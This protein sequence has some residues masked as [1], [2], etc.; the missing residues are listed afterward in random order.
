M[1][2]LSSLP[3]RSPSKR[4]RLHPGLGSELQCQLHSPLVIQGQPT[5]PAG[6]WCQSYSS[7]R[8]R[9]L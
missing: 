8:A 7:P 4:E 1:D 2:N 9:G 3:E 5:Q 6:R